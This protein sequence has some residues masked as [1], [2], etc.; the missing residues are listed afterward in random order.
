[1]GQAYMISK[2]AFLFLLLSYSSVPAVV[3]PGNFP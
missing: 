3:D 2:V 1:M